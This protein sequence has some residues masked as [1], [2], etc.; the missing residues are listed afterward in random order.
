MSLPAL[1]SALD[2]PLLPRIARVHSRRA[3]TRDV[4]TLD[5]RESDGGTAPFQPGQFNMLTV[6]GVGEIP[7]SM[8]GDPARGDRLLHTVR[9][10]GAVSRALTR[11]G[12]GA[13]I[14]VRGPFGSA[15]PLTAAAGRDVLVLAGGLGLAPLRPVLYRLRAERRRFGRI[16]LLYGAR[17]P[18]DLLF[19]RELERWQQ[20]GL[21]DVHMTVDHARDGWT[22]R[23]GVIT[24]LLPR[25]GFDPARTV[26]FV[27][28]PEVMMRV[29]ANALLACGLSD[30][31]VYV[32]LERNMKCAVG[33]CGRC[34][35][36]PLIVCRDGPVFRYDRVRVLLGQRE[37]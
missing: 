23:V 29:S 4:W 32:S 14:G 7:V 37:L 16:V 9:A 28:G 25:L 26:A 20:R 17:S 33:L 15:W 22:G 10:V 24:P 34:Q 27:C 3:D 12:A 11:L 5:V 30:E 36:G 19:R 21:F 8:S 13:T 1:T 2:D 31:A 6:F 18:A 35:L